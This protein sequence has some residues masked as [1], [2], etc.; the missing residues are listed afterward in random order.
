MKKAD[1][2][3]GLLFVASMM[4]LGYITILKAQRF[5]KTKIYRVKFP[6]V[7]G[8]KEGNPVRCEG[9]EVGEVVSLSLVEDY[10]LAVLEVKD[11]VKVY[12]YNSK[13]NVTPFSPLGGRVVEITRGQSASGELKPAILEGDEYRGDIHTGEA[14]GELLS[15]LQ[16]L[17]T[18]NRGKIDSIVSNI[19]AATDQLTK[20]NNLI[21]KLLNDKD[22]GDDASAIVSELRKASKSVA[23]V[24]SRVEQG[25]GILGELTVDD[26]PIQKN[27]R[28]AVEN[29]DG[30]LAEIR[31]VGARINE[32]PGLINTIVYDEDF[33]NDWKS[34]S[35]NVNTVTTQ[36]AEGRGIMKLVNEDDVYD[37]IRSFTSEI[38]VVAKKVNDPKA[39]AVG[40]LVSDPN[41]SKYLDVSFQN[42]SEIVTKA[43]NENGGPI[44]VLIGDQELGK[45]TRQ[46]F[47]EAGRVIREFRD[48]LED[49]REQAPV[50]AFI[51]TVFSAF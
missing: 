15:A 38:S 39:G 42:L 40:Y 50:N 2:V 33:A 30:A 17:I 25:E 21:G 26:R 18:A 7:Y 11:E 49:T 23:T 35:K 41:G 20:Q 10:V 31:K 1:L 28:S 48:S 19:E 3:V 43:N 13:F 9:K 6:K 32:G 8:L 37:N 22:L 5:G 12:Q 24:A 29:A 27:F 34:T 47:I 45:T 36:L 51:G 16:Q 14:E 46:I 44:G 4:A